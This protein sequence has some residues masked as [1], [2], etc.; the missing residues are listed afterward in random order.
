M[1]KE[2]LPSTSMMLQAS[3]KIWSSWSKKDSTNAQQLP[4][5][6]WKYD[7]Q[8]NSASV[9]IQRGRINRIVLQL[10]LNF[11]VQNYDFSFWYSKQTMSNVWPDQIVSNPL[12]TTALTSFADSAPLQPSVT[13]KWILR[14]QEKYAI[15]A[16]YITMYIRKNSNEGTIHENIPKKRDICG[17]QFTYK[18][19]ILYVTRK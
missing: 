15:T 10:F 6:T 19:F 2:I 7:R 8:P 11:Q 3:N 4:Y 5:S 16:I 9:V 13:K 18:N 1:K 14:W 12:Q 17:I